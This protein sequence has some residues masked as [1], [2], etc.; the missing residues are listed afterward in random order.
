MI[1]I[2]SFFKFHKRLAFSTA[3]LYK[4]A[5]ELGHFALVFLTL[6]AFYAFIGFNI[7]GEESEQFASMP[8]A[9]STV[10]HLFIADINWT[11]ETLQHNYIA[12]LI[13]FWSFL[14]ISYFILFN[15]VLSI[16][17][18]GYM[19]VKEEMRSS[20]SI[21]KTVQKSIGKKKKFNIR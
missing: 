15:V 20:D 5:S 8:M 16:I 11:P 10:M 7:F 12:G 2:F 19:A 4:T 14:A 9:F 18:D 21:F 1:R 17:V 13:F 6:N 3:V